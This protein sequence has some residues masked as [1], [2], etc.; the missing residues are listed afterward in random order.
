M[1]FRFYLFNQENTVKIREIFHIE[2]CRIEWF[3]CCLH[4]HC[5]LV[6]KWFLHVFISRTMMLESA[7][8]S[9]EFSLPP[10]I[11]VIEWNGKL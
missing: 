7:T 10:I 1:N 9:K 4:V 3:N 5:L 11:V 2:C 8:M 6:E